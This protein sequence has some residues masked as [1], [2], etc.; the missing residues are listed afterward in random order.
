MLAI[1]IE[2]EQLAEAVTSFAARHAPIDKTRACIDSI[3][4]G[5]LPTWWEE[6]TAHGFHAVH[7]PEELGGQGGTL[8]D[9]ACI[10]EAEQLCLLLGED[11]RG[12]ERV[13]TQAFSGSFR[14]SD[15]QRNEFLRAVAQRELR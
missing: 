4:A 2:Q 1:T 5:E 10:V 13:V 15:Q 14:N 7:L 3:A 11:R 6:F 12:D 8:A 9:T